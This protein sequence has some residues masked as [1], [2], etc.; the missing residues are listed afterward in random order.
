MQGVAHAA[1]QQA[2]TGQESLGRGVGVAVAGGTC[3]RARPPAAPGII[4]AGRARVG[5][6]VGQRLV[7]GHEVGGSGAAGAGLREGIGHAGREAVR[8]APQRERRAGFEALGEYL[9]QVAGP[10]IA[11]GAGRP[12]HPVI[13]QLAV[14]GEFGLQPGARTQR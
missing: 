7:P 11:F 13:D 12:L 4:E 10:P 5:G 3:S 2:E 8:A 1:A 14:G 6:H 9:A